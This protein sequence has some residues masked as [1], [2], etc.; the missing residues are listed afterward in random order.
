M[1]AAGFLSRGAAVNARKE[2]G[3]GIPGDHVGIDG[4]G[5]LVGAG[6]AGLHAIESLPVLA[7]R[8]PTHRE[9]HARSG[10]E[11]A[12]VGGVDEHP[13]GKSVSGEHLDGENA[14]ILLFNPV[15]AIEPLVAVHRDVVFL[16]EFLEDPLRH[17]RFEN[18]HGAL[19]TVDGGRALSPVSVLGALL[20]LPGCVV[21]VILP[22]AVVEL[23]GE[24]ADH[25][26]LSGVGPAQASRGKSAE[27]LV[28]AHDHDR[29]A[30]ALGLHGG[31]DTRGRAAVDDD[32]VDLSGEGR[33]NAKKQGKSDWGGTRHDASIRVESLIAVCAHRF[34]SQVR[35]EGPDSCVQHWPVPLISHSPPIGK[36]N[37][38]TSRRYLD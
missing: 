12:L 9:T 33:G 10:H 11:V 20:P 27:M 3:R 17:V 18:P 14:A 21:L 2:A 28:R 1:I 36:F 26:L 29:L 23:P 6:V 13:A 31:H 4:F 5:E 25:A 16:H 19:A 30:H 34:R 24:S 7:V 32:V 35:E 15:R 22:D 8:F 38:A 37:A